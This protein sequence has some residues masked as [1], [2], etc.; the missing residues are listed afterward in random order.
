MAEPVLETKPS[1]DDPGV[2]AFVRS[3]KAM[4]SA[5]VAGKELVWD[6]EE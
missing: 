5:I 6:G 4:D 3:Y 2:R 1:L